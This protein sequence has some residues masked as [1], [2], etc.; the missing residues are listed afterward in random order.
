MLPQAVRVDVLPSARL[1]RALLKEE[2]R[3]GAP[4]ALL[5]DGQN[6][7]RRALSRLTVSGPAEMCSVLGGQVLMPSLKV[8]KVA[9]LAQIHGPLARQKA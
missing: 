7:P 2:T 5:A 3:P 6:F 8:H 1:Q 9:W 4:A